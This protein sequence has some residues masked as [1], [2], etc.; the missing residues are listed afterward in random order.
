MSFT[1]LSIPAGSTTAVQ[2]TPSY[3]DAGGA[4]ITGGDPLVAAGGSA[5]TLS[6]TAVGTV[7]GAFSTSSSCAP[8]ATSFANW[9]ASST[10]YFCPNGFA[11][12]GTAQVAALSSSVQAAFFVQRPY[13]ASVFSTW[14]SNGSLSASSVTSVS[15]NDADAVYAIGYCCSSPFNHDNVAE[16]SYNNATAWP[17]VGYATFDLYPAYQ[18]PG[19]GYI[20]ASWIDQGNGPGEWA[21]SPTAYLNSEY[22]TGSPI[23]HNVVA[24]TSTDQ[25][26]IPSQ[27]YAAETDDSTTGNVDQIIWIGGVPSPRTSVLTLPYFP[28]SVAIGIS[29][30]VYVGY[31]N[32]GGIGVMNSNV[33][34]NHI[35][36]GPIAQAA[37][38][39][40]YTGSVVAGNAAAAYAVAYGAGKAL[41]IYALYGTTATKVATL[42]SL[43]DQLAFGSI[44]AGSAQTDAYDAAVGTD[45]RFYIVVKNGTT[46]RVIAFDPVTNTVIDPA[47]DVTSLD[48][49]RP[50]L[51]SPGQGR[52]HDRRRR[53]QRRQRHRRRAISLGRDRHFAAVT[54]RV[55]VALPQAPKHDRR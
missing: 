27:V 44:G 29:P 39:P 30:Y 43:S 24:F 15:G 26:G 45:G 13:A 5:L 22:N 32:S 53:A 18:T 8:T 40:G 12:L 34:S 46:D 42:G 28:H 14:H 41:E 47:I 9:T 31:S 7:D 48:A 3:T 33:G 35:L 25:T 11:T 38:D 6:L 19:S 54:D 36:T 20:M 21:F 2:L 16:A 55:T 49:A 50:I 51:L 23:T 52:D 4:A 37:V 10:L 17:Q 1:S